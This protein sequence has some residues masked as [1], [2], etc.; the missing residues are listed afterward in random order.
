MEKTAEEIKSGKQRSFDRVHDIQESLRTALE[1]AV[2]G[3]Q[4]LRDYYEN[5]SNGEVKLTCTFGDGVLEDTDKEFTRRMQMV[6]AGLLS[7]EKFIMWYFSCDE[8][9]A[10][11]YLPKM[12]S[13]FP[14]DEF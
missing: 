3:M 5:R 11:E 4:Y 6:S 10:K 1:N 2:Y 8:T 13:L 9:K 12:S 14:E 7:K